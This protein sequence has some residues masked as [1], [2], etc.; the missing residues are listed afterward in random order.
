M[1]Q[2]LQ[3]NDY[4]A[5]N[6]FDFGRFLKLKAIFSLITGVAAVLGIFFLVGWIFDMGSYLFYFTAIFFSGIMGLVLLGVGI[7]SFIFQIL[8][9]LAIYRAKES[10]PHSQLQKTSQF[11]LIGFIL[12]FV[13]LGIVSIILEL[14]AWDAFKKF[15]LS[16]DINQAYKNE[17]EK[18]IKSFIIL[19]IIAGVFSGILYIGVYFFIFFFGGLFYG[20]YYGFYYL[21]YGEELFI[22]IGFFALLIVGF[23]VVMPIIPQFKISKS[24][25]GVFEYAKYQPGTTPYSYKVQTQPQIQ[26][27]QQPPSLPQGNF[28]F[29][30][31]CGAKSVGNAKFCGYCGKNF[32]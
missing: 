28:K 12:R 14:I 7:T 10:Y 22:V 30:T 3:M 11:L 19:S 18:G 32:D 29:C 26:P 15:I 27:Y 20:F 13:G 31:K 25:M 9:L 8:M 4:T 1:N 16:G 23:M 17:I 5:K 2:M 6:L 21:F 24:L